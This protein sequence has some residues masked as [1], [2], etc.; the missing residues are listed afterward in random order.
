MYN[1]DDR[2]EFGDGVVNNEVGVDGPKFYR[3]VGQ[4]LSDVPDPG[5]GTEKRNGTT[6]LATHTPGDMDSCSLN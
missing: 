6:N 2:K 4:I 3:K 1:P 5:F